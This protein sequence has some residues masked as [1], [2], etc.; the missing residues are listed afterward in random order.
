[1][2]RRKRLLGHAGA[3]LEDYCAHHLEQKEAAGRVTP[4]HLAIRQTLKVAVEHLGSESPLD[5]IGVREVQDFMAALARRPNRRGGT[6]SAAARRQ[7]LNNLSN[8]YRRA[9]AE[10]VVP[11]GFNPCAALMDKPQPKRHEARWLEVHEAAL[12]LESARTYEPK[13]PDM[14]AP[15]IHA[16]L[17]TFLLT[18]G[19]KAEVLGLD[20][21]DVSFDRNVIMF[22]PNKH[23]RLKT[24]TSHRVVPLWPQLR[25]ILR[26]HLFGRDAASAGLLFP[27]PEGRMI[28]D[29]DK[30]LDVIAAR[31][32]WQVGEIRSRMFR[33]TYCSAR[34]Q[35]T[36]AGAAVSP[37]VVAKELGH[38]GMALVNRVYGH[39]GEIRQRSSVVEYFPE[40]HKKVLGDRLA[41]LEGVRGGW[42]RKEATARSA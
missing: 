15:S 20:V 41:A 3:R 22:R 26:D 28:G 6:L 27:G 30:Q 5:A 38:G 19:R 39:V 2:R 31:C 40:D 12:L 14:A 34:L 33:H 7:Y 16:I 17:A 42:P 25:A 24:L 4:Q 23:R 18:S 10:D 8:V 21:E 13:R 11:P 37:F 1:M 29:L 35:T 9:Q 32:D 36:D